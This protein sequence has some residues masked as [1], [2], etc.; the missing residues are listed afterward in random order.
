MTKIEPIYRIYSLLI[1]SAQ[2]KSGV[3]G[4]TIFHYNQGD[5][6]NIILIF[7]YFKPVSLS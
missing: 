4:L 6:N 7:I 3:F 5:F 1:Q 2:A